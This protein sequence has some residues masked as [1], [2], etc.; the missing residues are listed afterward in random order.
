MAPPTRLG[1]L[2]ATAHR[3]R[4]G[5]RPEMAPS[6]TANSSVAAVPTPARSGSGTDLGCA[7]TTA[8]TGCPA[9]GCGELGRALTVPRE[10]RTA[11]AS[12]CRSVHTRIDAPRMRSHSV[13]PC[14][15]EKALPPQK[16]PA[17]GADAPSPGSARAKGGAATSIVSTTTGRNHETCLSALGIPAILVEH[18]GI[19]APRKEWFGSEDRVVAHRAHDT[20]C[21]WIAQKLKHPPQAEWRW[22]HDHSPLSLP[23]AQW[24]A[25]RDRTTPRKNKSP[26]IRQGIGEALPRWR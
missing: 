22:T 13:R 25:Q 8:G 5:T 16:M 7:A 2:A 24:H 11:A 18:P 17:A 9:P 21:P 4:A 1:R 10:R 12:A 14:S 15:S 23:H 26:E 20:S 3:A 19:R 6:A